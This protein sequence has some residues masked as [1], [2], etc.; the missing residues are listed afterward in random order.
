MSPRF[1]RDAAQVLELLRLHAQIP[2]LVGCSSQGLIVGDQEVEEGAGLVLGRYSLPGAELSGFHFTQRQLEDSSGR[3]YWAGQTGVAGDRTNGWLVFADPF[4]DCEGWLRERA[5]G[6]CLR[7]GVGQRRSATRATQIYL[8]R[9]V[10][11]EGMAVSIG[12]QAGECHFPGCADW[13]D[14]NHHQ[15]GANSFTKS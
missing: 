2:L 10:Y 9:E 7:W 5:Y 12:G 6:P 4:T 11:E 13:R 8:N 1:F 3:G 14:V 15:G